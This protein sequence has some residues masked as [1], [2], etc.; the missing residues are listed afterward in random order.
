[1]SVKQEPLSPA[2]SANGSDFSGDGATS[3][4]SR[5]KTLHPFT[6]WNMLTEDITTTLY[7]DGMIFVVALVMVKYL[8]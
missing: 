4:V 3:Q 6:H 2:D 5:Y 1:M 8:L 7:V